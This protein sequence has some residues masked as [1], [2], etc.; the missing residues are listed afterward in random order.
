MQQPVNH[1]LHHQPQVCD[2]FSR[3][4]Y[5]VTPQMSMGQ[6]ENDTSLVGYRMIPIVTM[7]FEEINCPSGWD[8]NWCAQPSKQ[9]MLPLS[10]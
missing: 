3:I 10:Q 8:L 4:W 6:P 2:T 7:S 5:P 9:R 1:P